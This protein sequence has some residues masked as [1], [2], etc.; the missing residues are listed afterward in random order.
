MR[1]SLVCF[2]GEKGRVSEFLQV[3]ELLQRYRR[4]S[5]RQIGFKCEKEKVFFQS[6]MIFSENILRKLKRFGKI[7]CWKSI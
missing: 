6:F 1:I 5:G 3:C 4:K 2:F 7:K